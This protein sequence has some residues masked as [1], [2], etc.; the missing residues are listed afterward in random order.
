RSPCDDGR[1]WTVPLSFWKQKEVPLHEIRFHRDV[2][3][4]TRVALAF[5]CR[6]RHGLPDISEPPPVLGRW[7]HLSENREPLFDE[8][9]PSL[10]QPLLRRSD[11]RTI[12]THQQ[13]KQRRVLR[14]RFGRR[15]FVALIRHPVIVD[16]FQLSLPGWYDAELLCFSSLSQGNRQRERNRPQCHQ[17]VSLRAN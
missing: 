7:S 8:F 16:A 11:T 3:V 14:I 15:A 9:R 4:D 10:L 13:R 2:E 1:E 17:N 5:R 12:R 6:A